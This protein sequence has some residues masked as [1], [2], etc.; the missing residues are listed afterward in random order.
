MYISACCKCLNG[1]TTSAINHAFKEFEIMVQ[2]TWF[3]LPCSILFLV[4]FISF[5]YWLSIVAGSF[6]VSLIIGLCV[7]VNKIDNK[8]IDPI[9]KNEN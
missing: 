9:E 3:I 2:L 7:K 8:K 6:G 1:K 4:G 5:Y